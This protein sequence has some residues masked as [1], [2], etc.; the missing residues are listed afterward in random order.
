MKIVIYKKEEDKNDN[1][2]RNCPICERILFFHHYFVN[3]NISKMIDAERLKILWNDPRLA[4]SCC[5]CYEFI[6]KL[7]DPKWSF[8]IRKNGYN[9]ELSFS[10]NQQKKIYEISESVLKNLQLYGLVE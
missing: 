3:N 5:Y 6:I 2:E 4:I 10:R 7:T 8:Y 9:Y 1:R